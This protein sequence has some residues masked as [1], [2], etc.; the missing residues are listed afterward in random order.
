MESLYRPYTPEERR[1]LAEK[2][3]EF[4][5]LFLARVAQGRRRTPAEIDAVG[6]GR[7]WSGSRAREVGLVDHLGGLMVA[8]D[9]A[10]ALGDLGDDYEL[11]ELPAEPSGLLS[12]VAR[13][14]TDA[15]PAGPSLAALAT[16]A[17]ELRAPLGWLLSVHAGIGRPMALTDWPVLAP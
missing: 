9:R 5:N 1:F 15:G 13:L 14:V 12:T 8:L 10:R 6:E 11:T 7:V 17:P 16:G 4:Y 2:I 3:G